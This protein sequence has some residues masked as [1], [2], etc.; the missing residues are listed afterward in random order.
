MPSTAMTMANISS[1]VIVIRIWSIWPSWSSRNSAFVCTRACGN[2]SIAAVTAASPSSAVTPSARRATTKKSRGVA[3]GLTRSS[4]SMEISQF[5]ASE[6]SSKMPATGSVSIVP[7]W[8]V[9]STGSPSCRSRSSAG[10]LCTKMPPS[11][12]A[13]KSPSVTSMSTSCS[14]ANGSTAPTAFSSPS[15]SAAAPLTGVTADSSGCCA[16]VSATAGD[17]P[18]NDSSVMMKSAFTESSRISENV[19]RSDEANTAAALTRATPIISAAAVAD[20]RR[21]ERPAFSWA[22]FPGGPKTLATGQPSS[23]VT[24]RATVDERLATPRK[25]SSAP[26]PARVSAPTVP[27]GRANRPSTNITA[28]ITVTTVPST[29]RR[30]LIAS[31]PSSGRIAAT[32]G[33]RAARRAGT[34]TDS[35][36]TPMP[37]MAA[38]ITVRGS[39]TVDVSGKPAPAALKTARRPRATRMPPPMPSAVATTAITRA[40]V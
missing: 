21:G 23:R 18:W 11:A 22:S 26:R 10:S 27:P 14:K 38:M 5:P 1:T 6:A 37:T 30:V 28:P 32:G 34:M 9:I 3:A 7:F 29:R 20:V 39:S 25:M 16:S 4:V 12:S 19:A 33:M 31:N 2:G 36:V 13:W 8:N 35:I 17:R 24:G 15:T 40:S